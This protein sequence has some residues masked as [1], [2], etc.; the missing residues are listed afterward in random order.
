MSNERPLCYRCEHRAVGMEEGRGPR[1]ECWHEGAKVSCYMYKPVRPLVLEADGERDITLP[2][3]L[4]GRAH[5]T[6]L[7]PGEC[8]ERVCEDGSVMRWWRPTSE[9]R[10]VMEDK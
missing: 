8:V 1:H 3:I 6:R 2:P 5:S 10:G 7:M 9:G 4:A